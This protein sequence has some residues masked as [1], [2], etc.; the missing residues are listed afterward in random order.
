MKKT[1][2]DFC[3]EHGKEH[4]LVQWDTAGNLPDT[5]K[6]ISHGSRK[7]AWWVCDQGHRWQAAVQSRTA[8]N[9][10]C[11]VCA[12]KQVL[13]GFNDLASRYPDLAAQ[14][15]P[16]KKCGGAV[17]RGTSGRPPS[18]PG[19]PAAAAQSAPTGSWSPG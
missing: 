13:A 2:Y 6:T 16:T 18:S 8:P 4:L 12:G 11:P 10:Q 7:Q 15:H 9:N 5:P 3:L 17:S 1:F 19:W 14:W